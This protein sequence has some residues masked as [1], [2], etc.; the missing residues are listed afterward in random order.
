MEQDSFREIY[1]RY[2]AL[3][4]SMIA[5]AGV[6]ERDREDVF[7]ESWEAIFASLGSFVGR[8]SLATWIGRIVRNKAV[9][10]VRKS[11]PLSLEDAELLHRAETERS[12]PRSGPGK[13]VIRREAGELLG[14]FLQGLPAGRRL[15]VEKW[16]DGLSYRE[17]AG[18]VTERTG[19]AA[20][21]NYVGKELYL[22]KNRLS[23][24]LSAAGVSSL[25][26]IWE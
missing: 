25:E 15:I 22:A 17:I 16:L 20:D 5:R 23:G 19:R 9:D 3:V 12:E 2:G 4:W 10:R 21:T 6:P 24:M 8:S 26:D 14:K 7:M 11:I 13:E 1:G 18:Q